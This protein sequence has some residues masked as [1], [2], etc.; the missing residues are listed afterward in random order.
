MVK[1]IRAYE[2]K[3]RR[4]IRRDTKKEKDLRFPKRG[5]R[6]SNYNDMEDE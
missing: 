3:D 6:F 1:G 2:E 5:R 4:K